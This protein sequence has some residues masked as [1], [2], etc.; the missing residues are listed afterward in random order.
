MRL[1]HVAWLTQGFVACSLLTLRIA[2]AQLKLDEV[3]GTPQKRSLV[4][5]ASEQKTVNEGKQCPTPV[6][7]V[8]TGPLDVELPPNV[9]SVALV[10]IQGN[11]VFSKAEFR[12]AI[13]LISQSQAAQTFTLKQFSKEVE[14]AVTQLY[15][16]RGYIT[17]LAFAQPLEDMPKS[18]S[19]RSLKIQII[20]GRLAEIQVEGLR[21]L[22][23]SYICDRIQLGTTSPLNT[24]QLEDQLKLLRA[25]S[26]LT[27]IEASLRASGVSGQSKLTIR[28]V[29]APPFS[30]GFSIDNYSP[31]SVGSERLGI[32]LRYRNL[33]GIGDE[34]SSS[35]YHSTTDGVDNFD[36]AYQVPLNRMNGTLQLRAA[37]N[38]SN[39]TQPPFNELG[40]RGKQELYEINF[41]QPLVRSIAK[42]FAVSL[43]FTYQNGQT[44]LFDR[45][46]NPFGIGPDDDGV[47]RT[48]VIR[49]GQDLTLRDTQGIWSFRSQFNF[50]TGLFDAT[51]NES[52]IPDGYFFSWLGQV[53]RVQRLGSAQLL[54]IQA[55]VQLTPNSLLPSQQFVIGGGQSVRGFRQNARS[56]DNGL[57]FLIEDRIAIQR[58][59]SGVPTIQLAPF[60]ELG[61][62]WNQADN[63][64]QQSEQTFL[65]GAGLGLLWNEA[66]GL[67]GLSL[68][69]DYGI[70]LVNLSD[71]GNNAQDKGFYFSVRYQPR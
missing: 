10:T 65:A 15:L 42:E 69:V 11:T 46:P 5:Q 38:R 24:T 34:I 6:D 14:N 23:P 45:L 47:S 71:R 27:N 67:P 61:T 50:G 17:S 49:F 58:D 51:T 60:F 63:P 16:K 29:E 54:L 25:D 28:V 62:V 43:G 37:P 53:Q 2:Q 40:I 8:E 30:S 56:G 1:D 32:E 59:D 52:P 19:R 66:L 55:D 26:L 35:Y 12:Q 4:A 39:V 68:R 64:N 44:F 13:Q 7:P 33:T 18:P 57:R 41:R 21:R 22:R 36:F 70:P 48:S 3:W 31:P 20:E 9:V